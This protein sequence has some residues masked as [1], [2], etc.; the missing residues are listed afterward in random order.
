MS[1]PRSSVVISKIAAAQRQIDAA[2]RMVLVGEDKLAVYTVA[3]A[4]LKVLRDIMRKRGR[5]L[6]EDQH[7]HIVVG[8][9][10]Q[11]L[12]NEYSEV[13]DYIRNHDP[14]YYAM[15]EYAADVIRKE[16]TGG[17]RMKAEEI[18]KVCAS[19]EVEFAYRQRVDF[20]ANFLKHADKDAN[21]HWSD[22]GFDSETVLFEA[23]EAYLSV[24]R[25]VTPEML[26]YT[27]LIMMEHGSSSESFWGPLRHVERILEGA[28]QTERRAICWNLLKEKKNVL[29]DLLRL[30]TPYPQ[31]PAYTVVE[32]S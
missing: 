2:I 29:L 11:L 22:H 12:N 17:R 6:V 31:H 25:R 14:S 19:N 10:R 24:M 4:A 13:L 27:T 9:A 3:A 16:E 28:D 26:V 23:C 15:I 32:K 1:E 30:Y 20:P 7:L 8:A 5:S 18:F 21:G